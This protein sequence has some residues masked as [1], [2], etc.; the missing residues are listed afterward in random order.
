MKRLEIK[1]RSKT[2]IIDPDLDKDGDFELSIEHDSYGN[3]DV[4]IYL[5]AKDIE[6]LRDYLIKLKPIQSNQEEQ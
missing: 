5:T 6:E 3:E 2:L 4:Y 1:S